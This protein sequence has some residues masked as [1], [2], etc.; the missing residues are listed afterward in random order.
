MRGVAKLHITGFTN[1]FPATGAGSA[2]HD[3][4]LWKSR[5]EVACVPCPT[6]YMQHMVGIV[7]IFMDVNYHA[8]T[9]ECLP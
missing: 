9:K 5:F 7:Y 8:A 3:G 2:I 6:A 1:R 4:I